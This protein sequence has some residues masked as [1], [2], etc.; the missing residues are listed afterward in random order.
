MLVNIDQSL[1]F[2]LYEHDTSL[3]AA[4]LTTTLARE[5]GTFI[6]DPVTATADAP[7]H[8]LRTCAADGVPVLKGHGPGLRAVAAAARW[9]PTLPDVR[10]G[11]AGAGRQRLRSAPLPEFDSRRLLGL[12]GPREERV[13]TPVEAV[14]AAA[15]IGF[16]VVVKSDG[17]AHK[18]RVGGVVLGLVDDGRRACRGRA[19]G[20]R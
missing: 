5:T 11:P 19:A 1:R 17:P 20:R 4:E 3:L 8:I 2:E 13:A 6:G 15:R 16:P 14:A 18:E 10:R 7:D 9:S 12:N